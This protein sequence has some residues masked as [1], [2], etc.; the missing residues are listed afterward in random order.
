SSPQGEHE[1]LANPTFAVSDGEITIKF[2][3]YTLRQ[4]VDSERNG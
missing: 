4:I 3:P 2:H 1:R